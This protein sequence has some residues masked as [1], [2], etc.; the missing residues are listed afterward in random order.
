MHLLF[1]SF[2]NLKAREKTAESLLTV[3]IWS[4]LKKY[5]YIWVLYFT[6]LHC[7]ALKY[8]SDINLIWNQA[9]MKHEKEL[10]WP[11]VA[12]KL[13]NY[14]IYH[15]HPNLPQISTMALNPFSLFLFSWAVPMSQECWIFSLNFQVNHLK[16]TESIAYEIKDSFY[17]FTLFNCLSATQFWTSK[18]RCFSLLLAACLF[19]ICM[20]KLSKK[21]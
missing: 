3:W 10:A 17:V 16:E 13:Q 12:K 18:F 6:S 11:P 15:H 9:Y 5:N 21:Q 19:C 1:T 20:T 14:I 4:L 2:N 8:L 7:C